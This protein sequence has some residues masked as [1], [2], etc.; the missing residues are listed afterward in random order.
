MCSTLLSVSEKSVPVDTVALISADGL[1][2]YAVKLAA[3]K[4]TI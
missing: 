1:T 3:R 2:C 4:D